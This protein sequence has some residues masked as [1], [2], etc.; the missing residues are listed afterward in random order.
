MQL[1]TAYFS[2]S[3]RALAV[4]LALLF[5]EVEE[6]VAESNEKHVI[7]LHQGIKETLDTSSVHLDLVGFL[8]RIAKLSL[9]FTQLPDLRGEDR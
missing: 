3:D 5:E 4:K 9:N 8:Q 7:R 2:S 6:R 1:S